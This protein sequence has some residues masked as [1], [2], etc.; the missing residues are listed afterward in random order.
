[1]ESLTHPP[2]STAPWQL[3]AGYQPRGHVH[4]E[5]V[6]PGGDL[7]PHYDTFVR[8]LE[9]LGRH[10]LA[11]RWENAKRTIRDNGVTYNVYGDPEGVDR[12]WTL[13]MIPLVVPSS[14]WS[15][16]EAAL[17]QRARLLNA[18]LADLY[19]PQRLLHERHLPAP[20]LFGNPGF[21]RSCHGIAVPR[22]RAPGTRWRTASCCRAAC[23][24]RF[25]SARFSGS[26]R[27]SGR[28]ATR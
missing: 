27:S 4:D 28:S 16:L 5:L 12:P 11:S 26:P 23:P 14:E 2:G 13:D 22:R 3:L 24:R 18:I 10:E 7:R 15:R 19:G 6:A 17:I 21:L 9:A 20:L 25:A 8:S 1:M